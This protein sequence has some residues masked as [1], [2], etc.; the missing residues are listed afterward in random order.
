M[1]KANAAYALLEGIRYR[2]NEHTGQGEPDARWE[3]PVQR[4]WA[5]KLSRETRRKT[6]MNG[7]G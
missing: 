6:G 1:A 3:C 2:V 4:V 7:S 5:D